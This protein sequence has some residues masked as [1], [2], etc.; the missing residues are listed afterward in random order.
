[1][2]E[3]QGNVQL[4]QITTQLEALITG[5]EIS[6]FRI[7]EAARTV[8]IK[9]NFQAIFDWLKPFSLIQPYPK[10]EVIRAIRWAYCQRKKVEVIVDPRAVGTSFAYT[11]NALQGN[12][13]CASWESFFDARGVLFIRALNQQGKPHVLAVDVPNQLSKPLGTLTAHQAWSR[14]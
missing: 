10:L 11:I 5:D 2:T 3:E 6:E 9:T 12:P 4:N 7:K 1:M 14:T 8:G 13:D